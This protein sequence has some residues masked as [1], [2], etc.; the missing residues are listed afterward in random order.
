M[1]AS[2]YVVLIAVGFVDHGTAPITKGGTQGKPV[3][4]PV[5]QALT[6]TDV[7]VSVIVLALVLALALEADRYAGSMD[8]E[9]LSELRG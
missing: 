7:V 1:Q 2:T 9:A 4:D 3:V 5:V 8:P 6:L